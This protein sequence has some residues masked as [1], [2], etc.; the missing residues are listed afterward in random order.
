MENEKKLFS[1]RKLTVTAMFAAIAAVLMFLDF[2]IPALI[3]GFIKMDVSE[4]PAL[5]VALHLGPLYGVA[6]CLIKISISV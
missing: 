5:I 1:V 4:L 2:S 3:P 6:I